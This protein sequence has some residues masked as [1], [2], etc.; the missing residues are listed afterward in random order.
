MFYIT[1]ITYRAEISHNKNFANV[2]GI[3]EGLLRSNLQATF[4]GTTAE[5]KTKIDKET[6]NRVAAK[7]KSLKN[8]I[9]KSHK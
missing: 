8:G 7:V 3:M 9:D 5:L 1:T 2:S 6:D 4:V